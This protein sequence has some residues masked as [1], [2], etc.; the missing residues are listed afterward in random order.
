MFEALGQRFSTLFSGLR[1]KVTQPQL[2]EFVQDIK[3]ALIE[4]DVALEVA[5]IFSAKILEKFQEKSDV[6]NII[7][8]LCSF[9]LANFRLALAT[10]TGSP[11]PFPGSGAKTGIFID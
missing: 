5:D 2:V 11:T 6:I 1:G 3:I 10:P 7:T 8:K 9:S 4:S